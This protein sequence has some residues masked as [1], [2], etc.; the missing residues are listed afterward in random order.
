MKLRV[1][2]CKYTEK[3]TDGDFRWML[4]QPQYAMSL[5]LYSENVVD[6]L[7]QENKGGGTACLR[8]FTYNAHKLMKIECEP[9]AAGLPTGWSR[10]SR[11]FSR[12]DN[13][14][15]EAI[16]FAFDHIV[17]LIRELKTIDTVIYSCAENDY[18]IGV[19]I[20]KGSLSDEVVSYITARIHVLPLAM[21]HCDKVESIESIYEKQLKLLP[22]ALMCQE[23]AELRHENRL[24][25]KQLES[26]PKRKRRVPVPAKLVDIE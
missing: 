25:K 20:F 12:L 3:N 23:V 7:T 14:T 10:Q 24:L 9:R 2:S 21:S 26:M 19:N 17:A 15:K 16:N 18:D 11:G 6:W 13:L 8:P 4:R 22:Y 1:L 5:F